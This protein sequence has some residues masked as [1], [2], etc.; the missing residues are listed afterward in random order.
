[1]LAADEMELHI[2]RLRVGRII[3]EVGV[4]RHRDRLH[5]DVSVRQIDGFPDQRGVVADRRSEHHIDAA[6]LRHVQKDIRLQNVG[7]IFGRI[8]E[9]VSPDRLARIGSGSVKTRQHARGAAAVP[10]DV[11]RLGL[12]DGSGYEI[13]PRRIERDPLHLPDIAAGGEIKAAVLFPDDQ[14]PFLR[15]ESAGK[16]AKAG[17]VAAVGR[18][19]A[20]AEFRLGIGSAEV[21]AV[22]AR[23]VGN[24][25]VLQIRRRSILRKEIERAVRN[26]Q[27]VERQQFRSGSGIDARTLLCGIIAECR[28][29]IVDQRGDAGSRKPRAPLP[30]RRI[31][32]KGRIDCRRG[33]GIPDRAAVDGGI[34][35]EI[36]VVDAHR[37]GGVRNRP[38]AAGGFVPG[39]NSLVNRKAAA[40]EHRAAGSGGVARKQ[41]I[42]RGEHSGIPDRA[43]IAGHRQAGKF[44][45]GKRQ[46]PP[47]HHRAAVPRHAFAVSRHGEVG[48]RHVA[49]LYLE[50]S[51]PGGN[52]N[53]FTAPLPDDGKV[54]ADG[55]LPVQQNAR[56]QPV[57]RVDALVIQRRLKSGNRVEMRCVSGGFGAA[58]C[59]ISL[60]QDCADIAGRA[61]V[62]ITALVMVEL[63]FRCRGGIARRGNPHRYLIFRSAVAVEEG[64][65][66]PVGVPRLH[67]DRRRGKAGGI[68]AQGNRF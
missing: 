35:A 6:P 38:A 61:A 63:P 26:S 53:R 33:S 34:R 36:R 12:R 23:R 49:R 52:Q 20:A 40:I 58:P 46:R 60:P 55:Q 39:K 25:I 3:F 44:D 51:I 54:A 47:V 5:I 24:D 56:I 67:T 9:I 31:A 64:V 13:R 59:D 19:A 14:I 27:I 50:N 1:M 48:Y 18:I 68:L 7:D 4:I 15:R 2:R 11:H 37:A 66:P 21:G 65:D 8:R 28:N 43:A 41:D 22:H 45:I 32:V 42:D 17:H 57:E 16:H 30:G 29:R 62:K 10:A